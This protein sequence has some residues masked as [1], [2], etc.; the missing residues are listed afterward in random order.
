MT[1]LCRCENIETSEGVPLDVTGVA[2]VIT[3]NE[4][5]QPNETA[6][7]ISS[8]R[9]VKGGGLVQFPKLHT[10]TCSHALFH[11]LVL[12]FLCSEGEPVISHYPFLEFG[13]AALMAH[14]TNVSRQPVLTVESVMMLNVSD[15]LSGILWVGK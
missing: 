6:R 13:Y 12:V 8:T 10:Y 15:G 3:L 11:T 2:Q 9:D 7:T 1:I 5:S 4:S 14:V